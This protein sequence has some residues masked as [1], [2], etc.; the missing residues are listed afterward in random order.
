VLYPTGNLYF[1]W[2]EFCGGVFGE[3]GR[4]SGRIGEFRRKVEDDLLFDCLVGA[5]F[6][7]SEF[8]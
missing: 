3:K 6:P 2:I 1:S 8:L 5:N 4:L 7:R